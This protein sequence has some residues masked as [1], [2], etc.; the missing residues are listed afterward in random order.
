MNKTFII[1]ALL[2][3][4]AI[5]A[6][7]QTSD[8][9]WK[10]LPEYIG[11]TNDFEGVFTKEQIK[12][13]DS[14]MRSYEERTS[15]QICVATIP[16]TATPEEKFE[17]LTLHI[18]K[19][20][21]VGKKETNNGIFIGIAA[22]YRRMRIQNGY[23]TEKILS[24]NETK[25]IIDSVFLP[26]F[27]TGNYYKGTFDGILE[28]IKVLDSNTKASAPAFNDINTN[29]DNFDSTKSVFEKY[30]KEYYPDLIYSYDSIA[31]IHNYSNNWDFDN[32]GIKDQLYFV[33]EDD[34]FSFYYLKIVLSANQQSAGLDFI[35]TDFP[36]LSNPTNA[37]KLKTGFLVNDDENKPPM[38]IVN[39]NK[40]VYNTNNK[41]MV[42]NNIKAGNVF[43]TFENGVFKFGNI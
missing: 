36:F 19:S 24:D 42:A 31:D 43:V 40:V 26:E 41:K 8:S 2:F 4:S 9:Y 22:G 18:A 30:Y 34:L 7:S 6:T 14:L 5:L 20:W 33:R 32:D 25:H 17:D 29:P 38:I 3:C 11:Y 23:G 16:A 15:I 37:K 21:G 12:K 35:Q 13:L 27:K 10:N 39:I 28:I 1:L